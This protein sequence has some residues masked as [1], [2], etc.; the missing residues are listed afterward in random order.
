MFSQN[1][2][3]QEAF[4]TVAKMNKELN[5]VEFDGAFCTE[6]KLLL[7]RFSSFFC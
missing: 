7:D 3:L 5:R 6:L 4:E 1:L 2:T